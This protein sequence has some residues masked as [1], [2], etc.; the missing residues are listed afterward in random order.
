MVIADAPR[1]N[2]GSRADKQICRVYAA[3]NFFFFSFFF[4][5]TSQTLHLSSFIRVKCFRER[6]EIGC[7]SS[8]T[9]VEKRRE[10][11]GAF[12]L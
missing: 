12:E 2:A 9:R 3:S 8:F 4:P 11:R 7:C 5:R 10:N 6:L 1:I